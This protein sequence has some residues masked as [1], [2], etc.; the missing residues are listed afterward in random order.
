MVD[1]LWAAGKT[2]VLV[3]PIPDFD[4]D[5][6]AALGRML[7]T[8]RDPSSLQLPLASFHER[9][10]SIFAI[11][12]RAGESPRILRVYPHKRL[13]DEVHCLAFADGKALFKDNDH[14]SANGAS[15]VL[16]AFDA[17]FAGRDAPSIAKASPEITSALPVNRVS[18]QQ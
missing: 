15:Y 4:Y 8:G 10:D 16:P 14:L 6:S 2:V 17:V 5:V 9:Q 12:D 1:R 7:A 11:L 18:A 13:C 3:Y